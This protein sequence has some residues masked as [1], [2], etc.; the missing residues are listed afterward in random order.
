MTTEKEEETCI[1][2]CEPLQIISIG[3]CNH[4]NVCSLC[5]LRR[6]ELYKEKTC[7]CK[8]PMDRVI[9]TTTC[10]LKKLKSFEKFN[11]TSLSTTPKLVDCYFEDP[12][13]KKQV[14][15]LW[16]F[17][18][19]ECQKDGFHS[20]P[21][22]KRH[23]QEQHQLF[24]CPVCLENK[25]VFLH[26]QP[27][28][29]KSALP[30]H[31][32]GDPKNDDAHQWCKFCERSFYN[33]NALYK[34]MTEKHESCHL[35][36]QQGIHFNY[37]HNYIE[38]ERH[39]KNK[40]FLCPERECLEK[41]FVVFKT[42]VD[43]QAH[44]VSVHMPHRKLS[45]GEKREA[46]RLNLE[47]VYTD[48]PSRFL[49]HQQQHTR[50]NRGDPRQQNHNGL[51]EADP[52]LPPT[53]TSSQLEPLNSSH[54]PTLS[55]ASS[56][57]TAPVALN[58]QWGPRNTSQ[59]HLMSEDLWPTLPHQTREVPPPP[60]RT[61]LYGGNYGGGGGGG[62]QGAWWGSVPPTTTT[63]AA[64]VPRSAASK[65]KQQRGSSKEVLFKAG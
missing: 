35:C 52:Y 44:D 30:T 61:E 9:F 16:E 55:P 34:H 64:A 29:Q 57:S 5:C 24:Y 18:C 2:C 54:F 48:S 58:S 21:H 8:Q 31:L 23:M 12:E 47:L 42:A 10:S 49:P 32:R 22:L 4:S 15:K 3:E 62:L 63:T 39:F 17:K 1:I 11:L 56:T 65:R 13:Y 6:R 27:L 41:K 51:D 20:L 50:R 33:K 43:L 40:H 60:P 14:L 59:A 25:A 37:Y 36:Q 26:E 28:F 45:K 46:A 7:W 19:T 38:L 53:Q